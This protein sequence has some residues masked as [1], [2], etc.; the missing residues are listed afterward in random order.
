MTP[1]SNN[2]AERDLRMA[3]L[4]QKISGSFRTFAGD[5]AFCAI[6]SYLQTARKHRLQRLDVLV[7]LFKGNLWVPSP[8]ATP[9]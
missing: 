9:P 4:Q 5:K 2:Q 1:W 7:Q 6:K 8:A 3:T